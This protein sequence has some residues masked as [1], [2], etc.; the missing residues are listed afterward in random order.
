MEIESMQCEK[1]QKQTV[2]K[3]IEAWDQKT[4]GRKKVAVNSY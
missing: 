3:E 1:I 4:K 2:T